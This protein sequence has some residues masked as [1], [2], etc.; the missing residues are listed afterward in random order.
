MKTDL[1]IVIL[2]AGLGTRMK[3]KKAKVLHEAGG[4]TLVEHVVDRALEFAA[5]Q[6]IVAVT[7]HQ[8]EEVEGKLR[9][10]GVQ[11]VRQVEQMGTGHALRICREHMADHQGRLIVLYGDCPLIAATTL[12]A[13]L[14]HHESSRAAATVITTL[15]EDPT[16]YGRMVVDESGYVQAIVE[17]KVATADQQQI[18]QINS[19]IYCFEAD[20]LWKYIA[21]IEPNPVSC[22]YYLTDIVEILNGAGHRVS[23]ML[24]ADASELLGINTRLELAVVDRIF[25]ERKVRELMLAGVTIR[26]PETVTI[27]LH[28]QVGMDSVIESG[29]QLLGDTVIGE[30]CRI[31]AGAIVQDSRLSARVVVAPYTLI[32]SST[33]EEDASVGP[34]ARLRANNHIGAGAHIGNFVE[35]K[36]T[37]V[38]SRTKAGHLAYLGDSVIGEGANIGAGTITCNYDGVR[39]HETIIGDG[40]FVGSNATLVA[41]LQIGE[42]SY[43]AAG[44]VITSTI[45]PDALALGRSRQTN[46][47][48]WAKRKRQRK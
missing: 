15:L 26:K 37:R 24:H 46:K 3:S 16:G 7:G 22:E 27:D 35:L 29:V 28:V 45:P 6:R 34:F 31:G 30:D 19:G 23:A 18:Q 41:P 39:K 38:G 20:L 12:E 11:F 21:K 10:R 33:I 5:P 17:Q 4:Q 14:N 32:G 9:L 42:G 47:E 13:L 40:V 43:I 25:R 36:K 48:G 1:N 44:S 8:A 2:A